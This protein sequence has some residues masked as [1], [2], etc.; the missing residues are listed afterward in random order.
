MLLDEHLSLLKLRLI[1]KCH[2]NFLLEAFRLLIKHVV[3]LPIC[4]AP[5]S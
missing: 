3:E 4:L 5:L 1:L 2:K